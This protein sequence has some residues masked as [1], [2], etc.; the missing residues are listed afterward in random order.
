MLNLIE[1]TIEKI[2][3][4]EKL[5][6]RLQKSWQNQEK[7]VVVWRPDSRRMAV[8]HNGRYW[9]GSL[10]LGPKE[11][12]IPRRWY[13]FGEYRES[14]NLEIAIELNMPWSNDK[15]VSGFFAKDAE[16]GAVYLMHDGGVGGGRKGV[17]RMPFLAWSNSKLVPV[18]GADDVRLAVVVA[19]VD[20]SSTAADIARFVQSAIDFKEAAARGETTTPQALAA[21]RRFGKYFDEFSGKK[22]RRRLEEIEYISRHG[23]IVRAVHDWRESTLRRNEKLFK[24][25]YVDLGVQAGGV[26]REIYEVKSSCERQSLYT[27]IGQVVVHDDTQC[28][29]CKRFLVL[30]DGEAIPTDVARALT[31]ADISLIRFTLQGEKV[32]LSQPKP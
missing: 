3:A 7:R 24:D 6:A 30:P 15:R 29:D 14:G 32:R 22:R 2:Y 25:G 1:T 4:Q 18:A 9:Y 20:A 28:G 8:H 13:P 19:P 11:V 10:P 16:T 17:G 12:S 23:D 31:R 5:E 26:L 27:A 21:Q